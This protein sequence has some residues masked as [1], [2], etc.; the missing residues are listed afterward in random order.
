MSVTEPTP[1][2]LPTVPAVTVPVTRVKPGLLTTEFWLS[3]IASLFLTLN[4]TGA[5]TYVHPQ[6]ASLIAQGV[7]IGAYTFSRGWAK[8]GPKLG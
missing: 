6:W 1:P 3:L 7:I 8:S 5:W 2:T 4:T